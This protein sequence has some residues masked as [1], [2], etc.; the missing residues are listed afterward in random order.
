[1]M[2]YRVGLAV[3]EAILVSI[4]DM[5]SCQTPRYRDKTI[6]KLAPLILG[7]RHDLQLHNFG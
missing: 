6:T 7:V 4:H 5:P 3:G 2:E 1:M